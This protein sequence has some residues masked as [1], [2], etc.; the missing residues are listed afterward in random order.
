MVIQGHDHLCCLAGNL[1]Q[2]R[3]DSSPSRLDSSSLGPV[4]T[5][6]QC[7]PISVSHQYLL[8]PKTDIVS[9][10]DKS[11]WGS[12][13][14]DSKWQRAFQQLCSSLLLSHAITIAG[15]N[16]GRASLTVDVEGQQS[17][18]WGDHNHSLAPKLGW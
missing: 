5:L 2:Q 15:L 1:K 16:W 17:K 14:L 11:N 18:V 10:V 6:E 9:E 8:L 4:T 13:W 12:C 7:I 3:R